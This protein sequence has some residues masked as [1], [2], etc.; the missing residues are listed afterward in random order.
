M[1]IVRAENENG[2][3]RPS[4]PSQP[5]RTTGKKG[6]PANRDQPAGDTIDDADSQLARIRLGK[7]TFFP[8]RPETFKP[9]VLVVGGEQLVKLLEVKTINATSVRLVWRLMKQEPLIR[10]YYVKWQ[11]G[12]LVRNGPW[13]NIT[14]P[15]ATSIVIQQLKPYT[16]YTFFVIPYHKAVVGQP[17]NS[18]DGATEEAGK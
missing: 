1:F 3:G 9:S 4:Q 14:D 2:I 16:T 7:F 10:G 17:S 6:S 15:Q 8:G 5:M 13:V 12:P 18:L 11:G